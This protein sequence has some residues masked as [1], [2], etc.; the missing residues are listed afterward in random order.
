MRPWLAL[1]LALAGPCAARAAG[2]PMLLTDFSGDLPEGDADLVVSLRFRAIRPFDGA[3]G[4]VVV[5]LQRRGGQWAEGHR[6]AADYNER[7]KNSCSLVAGRLGPEGVRGEVRVTIG[8]DGA[9][10]GREHFPTPPD[11]FA[12][13]FQATRHADRLLPYQEDREAFMPPWRKDTPRFGGQLLTGTYRATWTWKGEAREREGEL[14]GAVSPAPAPGRWGVEGNAVLAP[15]AGGGVRLLARLPPHRVGSYGTAWAEK[16]L[17]E[18]GDWRPFR[19]LRLTVGS[20]KRRDDAAAA[21]ALQGAGGRWF[22]AH[23]AGPLLG[24][25]VTFEVPFEDLGYGWR[26][27][28]LDG[29]RALRLG[30]ANRHGVGDV[31]FVV[32]RIELLPR[33]EAP[34]REGPVEVRVE[35]SV[36]VALNGASRVP[37]GLFGFHGGIGGKPPTDPREQAEALA[38]MERL[39]PGYVRSIVHTGFGAEPITDAEIDQMR[40]ERLARTQEPESWAYRRA[41]AGNLVD[42]V[43]WCHTQDLWA[44]PSWMRTSPREFAEKVRRFYRRQGAMAWVP[45]DR[46][47]LL[48]RFEVWNEPFMW[49][50]HINMGFRLPRGAK[51]WTDPTQY[52]YIPGK[53][54]A[55]AWATLFLAAVKGAKSANPHV[56]L[57]GP[58]APSFE[59]DDFG[60]FTNYVARIIDRCHPRLDFLTEHHYG[61]DPRTP[62]AAYEVA[63]A[64]CDVRHGRRIPIRN[65]ETNDLFGSDAAKAAYN[66]AD[67]LTLLRTCPDKAEARAMHYFGGLTLGSKGEEHAYLLLSALRGTLVRCEAAHPEVIAVAA[68]PREG[69][70]VVVALNYTAQHQRLELPIPPGFRLAHTRVLLADAPRAEADLRDTDGARV[71]APA[72]GKTA[73]HDL[74]PAG[75]RP[76]V[77]LPRRSAVRWML[78]KPGYRSS[79]TAATEQHFADAVLA[80]VAP[81]QTLRARVLWRGKTE[82]ARSARLRLVTRGAGRGEAVAAVGGHR[83]PLPPSPSTVRVQEVPLEP[84]WLAP[85]T[86]LEFRCADPGRANGYTV[87]AASVLLGR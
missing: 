43:V 77:A 67:I 9:R 24:G 75:K 25:E 73:L 8:P 26:R 65:T 68:T 55:E 69:E 87:C 64:Y 85:D 71:P 66:I 83:V 10:R 59:S 36:A 32:R 44:R 74:G 78:R 17:E 47:N 40:R 30:V 41:R 49:G 14:V 28:R 61:G 29:V 37:K 12:I 53:L 27:P 22:A 51:A 3:A 58:A 2:E 79:R 63:T 19:A 50:R 86:T 18:P 84:R 21:V 35:P 5:Q 52:G 76:A 39:K 42:N 38:Y 7:S 4:D 33:D 45:G 16:L 6:A 11:Q 56:R 62:A 46:F 80:P 1:L 34:P 82:G 72:E 31:A 48:R 70:L 81:G 13:A 20:A 54:G 57:G 60:V 15:A 23:D